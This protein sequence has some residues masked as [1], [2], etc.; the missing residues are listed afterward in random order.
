MNI[1]WVGTGV[2]G[3]SMAAHLLT[4]GHKLYCYNRTR[5]KMD[6]LKKKAQLFV[7]LLPKL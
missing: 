2:M 1:A 7:T 6:P 5:A 4:A 3:A